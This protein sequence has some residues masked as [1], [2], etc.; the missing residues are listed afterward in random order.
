MAENTSGLPKASQT[1]PERTRKPTSRF[2][3]PRKRLVLLCMFSV[4]V[5]CIAWHF[6]SPHLYLWQARRLLQKDPSAAAL[7]LEHDVLARAGSFPEAEVL[8]SH[9][10]LRTGRWAEA[11]GA[12]SQIEDAHAADPAALVALALESMERKVYPLAGMASNAVKDD[13]TERPQAVEILLKLAEREGNF[14]AVLK[15][16]DELDRIAPDR[17]GTGLLRARALEQLMDLP[18]AAVAY[19]EALERP[20]K[21]DDV[22]PILR[23]LVRIYIQLARPFEA[24]VQLN[25]L[26]SQSIGHSSMDDRLSEARVQ[27]LEGNIEG[28]K[29]SLEEVL[30]N[31]RSDSEV[32]ELRAT[33]AIDSRDYQAAILDLQSVLTEQPWN[34]Q[35][36]YKLAQALTKCGRQEAAAHHLK[37]NRR[38]LELSNRIVSL[39]AKTNRTQEE[40][41]E[42]I[43]ALE[44]SGMKAT[45]AN[46]RQR[47]QIP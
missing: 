28:A 13:S 18:A 5:G 17:T 32:L 21:T 1:L 46:L 39:R 11:L 22:L 43:Q 23:S 31:G 2:L 44:D 15:L 41:D 37:E 9:A 27:R 25:Q 24:R 6:G 30:R 33:L 16:I 42:L 12:F 26:L 20:E 29:R 38:L 19:E 40:T 8:W 34:K 36:H 35:A 4:V 3:R 7:I 14:V 10:L 47:S 45:A